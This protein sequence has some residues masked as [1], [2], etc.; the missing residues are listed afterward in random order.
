MFLLSSSERRCNVS[1]LSDDNVMRPIAMYSKLYYF[2][3]FFLQFY[4]PMGRHR[5]ICFVVFLSI[6]LQMD[7]PAIVHVGYEDNYYFPKTTRS[8]LFN[9]IININIYVVI[10]ILIIKLNKENLH[11]FTLTLSA[12]R[13]FP[14]RERTASREEIDYYTTTT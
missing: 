1:I 14:I 3:F 12:Y 8:F 11:A 9:Q 4:N 10:I 2:S 13:K 7:Q 6:N 5:G